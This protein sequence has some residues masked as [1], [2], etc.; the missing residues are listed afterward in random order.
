MNHCEIDQLRS[1]L[2]AWLESHDV[3]SS[4]LM[5]QVSGSNENMPDLLDRASFHSEME[6]TFF[7][8]GRESEN[9]NNIIRA[10]K[11]IEKGDYGICEECGERIS[12]KRLKAVPDT[13]YC[14]SCKIELES[15]EMVAN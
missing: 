10:L 7:N 14:L 4:D 8:L 11:R 13:T 2:S 9:K 12:L 5:A 1:T 15:M 3:N 6:I